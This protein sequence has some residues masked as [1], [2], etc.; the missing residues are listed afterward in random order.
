[1]T[2]DV[3]ITAPSS[4]VTG[5]RLLRHQAIH[6]ALQDGRRHF[7]VAGAS[8]T[9]Q[10]D[11]PAITSN[12]KPGAIKAGILGEQKTSKVI[13]QWMTR[14]PAAVLIDS[15]HI[16]DTPQ[17]PHTSTWAGDGYDD[18]PD[19]DHVLII[20]SH[21]ILIDSKA[22][23]SKRKYTVNDKGV[24]LRGGRTFPGGNVHARQAAHLW[25]RHLGGSVKVNSI[26]CVSSDKVFVQFK[27]EWPRQGFQLVSLDNLTRTLDYRVGRM[28][29]KDTGRI[30][31]PL[32][33]E[34]AALCIKPYMRF[35]E[36]F[37]RDIRL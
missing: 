17:K 10:I 1:M 20:G 21:V 23:K 19:T 22:W 27:K 29:P 16:K 13:R 18:K 28:S 2:T 24:V 9:H 11:N 32:V 14:Y 34:V 15:V 6:Q 35:Q 33:A 7:G 36:F 8:L 25:S 31:T 30:R 5:N 12:F 3:E 37:G 4:K 26:V